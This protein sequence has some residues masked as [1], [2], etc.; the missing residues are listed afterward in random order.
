MDTLFL[1][2]GEAVWIVLGPGIMWLLAAAAVGFIFLGLMALM[3]RLLR[4]G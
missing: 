4:R 1:E 2:F 3:L